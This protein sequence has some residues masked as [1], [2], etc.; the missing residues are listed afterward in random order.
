MDDQ[1]NITEQNGFNQAKGEILSSIKGFKVHAF[2]NH[3]Q[4]FNH[5]HMHGSEYTHKW[6]K[7]LNLAP[8]PRKN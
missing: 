6:N 1:Q 5:Q 4:H 7:T 3:G 8:K 2:K